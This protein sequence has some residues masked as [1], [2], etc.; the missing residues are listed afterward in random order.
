MD[1]IESG[2]LYAGGP[3]QALERILD[4]AIQFCHGMEHAHSKGMI[5]RDIK[6]ENV[7]MTKEGVLK[8]TDFGLVRTGA[9]TGGDRAKAG[10]SGKGMTRLGD[11]MGTEGFMAPEQFTD[12]AGVLRMKE[13][14]SGT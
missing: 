6:P 3:E 13:R 14:V 12:A 7:L 2:K 11:V 9:V 4:L 8:I 1:W 10:G 5:H